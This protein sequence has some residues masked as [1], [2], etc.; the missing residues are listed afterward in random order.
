[1][2]MKRP[3]RVGLLLAVCVAVAGLAAACGSATH[4]AGGSV[5]DAG[6]GGHADGGSLPDGTLFDAIGIVG[7]GADSGGILGDD[8][9]STPVGGP[10]DLE[11][12]D[13]AIDVNYGD[14]TPTV[15]YSATVNGVSVAAT[16]VVDRGE[17]ASIDASSGMLA[18]TG[19]I[20]GVVTVTA[21]YQGISATTTLTVRV[22]LVDN[23]APA[24]ATDGGG[25]GGNGG[26]GGEGPGGPVDAP[27][28]AVLQGQPASDPG[29]A[30]LYPYDQ[31]VWP[32]GLLAPL[33]QWSAGQSY[34]AVFIHLQETSFEYQGYFSATATPFVHH[35]IPQAAWDAL[36]YSNAGENVSV[37]VVF[38]AAGQAYGPLTETWKIAAGRLEGTVYYQSYG[39]ALAQNLCCTYGSTTQQFGGATLAIK[40]GL[41][42]PMLVAGGNGQCRVCHSVSADGSRLV[43]QD[44]ASGDL[45]S[46][47]YNLAAGTAGTAL[48]PADDRFAWAAIYPD[49]TFLL[50]DGAPMFKVGWS[51]TELFSLPS[52]AALASTGI[53]AGLKPGSPAFSPDGHHVAFNYYAGAAGDMK[54]LAMMDFDPRRTHSRTSR[55][56]THL[57][58]ARR[59]GRR[60]CRRMTQLSSSSKPLATV[61]TSAARGRRVTTVVCA[62]TAEPRRS[63]GR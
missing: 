4:P 11:P 39:T 43:T 42:D 44:S 41:T 63:C 47:T 30:W 37:T 60:S 18:P 36:S 33:L 55:S 40:H 29:L 14:N 46:W 3:S 26:V 38:S 51:P 9:G 31:T 32:R 21:S 15:T 45:A 1:M 52:G 59:Y 62:R 50:S 16:F 2:C 48:T 56:S 17:I 10:V 19:T 6:R 13:Q 5:F 58:T 27:T 25:A 57:R 49:G 8:G 54:S 35:P 53:P 12:T 22:H 20:G 24:A 7:P 61:A 23:G 34:D 28:Q